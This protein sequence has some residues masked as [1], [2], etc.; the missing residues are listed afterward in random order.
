MDVDLNESNYSYSNNHVV[1]IS[2]FGLSHLIPTGSSKAYLKYKCGTHA[3]TAPKVVSVILFN[4]G[5]VY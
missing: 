3:Y 1:K 5:Y 2:D 4:L